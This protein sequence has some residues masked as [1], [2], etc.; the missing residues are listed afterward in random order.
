MRISALLAAPLAG[1]ACVGP[2]RAES[3]APGAAATFKEMPCPDAEHV[4]CP[5]LAAM[6][7][8]ARRAVPQ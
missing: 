6:T 8:I 4:R 2:V 7:C 5:Y 1:L 3:P